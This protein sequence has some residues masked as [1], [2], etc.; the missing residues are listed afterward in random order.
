M[1]FEIRPYHPDDL[2][3]LYR[4]CLQTGDSGKDATDLVEDTKLLGHY[5]MAPYVN[6]EPEICFVVVHNQALCG[7]IIGCKSSSSFALKCEKS[8]FPD[9]RLQYISPETSDLS[10]DARL[11]RLIHIGYQP[12]VEYVDYPAHLHINLLPATQG[13]GIGRKLITTFLKHLKALQISGVHLEV[14]RS[15]ASAIS[16]YEKL[17]FTAICEFEHSIGYGIKL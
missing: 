11:K 3:A 10:Y 15:N 14:S 13:H 6:F 2:D 12:R 16:F 7:Y 1:S 4:I 8:W 9:L 17:G 5:Y